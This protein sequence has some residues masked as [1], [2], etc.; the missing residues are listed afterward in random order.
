MI[1]IRSEIE[2]KKMKKA[3]KVVR[4]LLF[5]IESMIK[6]GITTLELDKYAENYIIEKKA[7]PGFKGL[8]GFPA[9]I[10]VSINDEVVGV[11]I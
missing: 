3:A 9:T 1:N 11:I 7:V 6:P 10:C 4:D 2:V 5:D 8:Y